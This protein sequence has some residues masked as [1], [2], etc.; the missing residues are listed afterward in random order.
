M[1]EK[2]S[3]FFGSF[4]PGT[5]RRLSI[6]EFRNLQRQARQL[7]TDNE[8]LRAQLEVREKPIYGPHSTHSWFADLVRAQH[9]GHG[10][11]GDGGSGAAAER[12]S[13]HNR[14]Q[15]AEDGRRL[16]LLRAEAEYAAER[17]LSRSP[18]E[19]ALLRRWQDRGGELFEMHQDLRDLERRALNRTD[20]T[21]GYFAPP[22]WLV[23]R[24]VHAPRAGA[25]FAALWQRLPMPPGISSINL[26]RF[27]AGEE[28]GAMTDGASVPSGGGTDSALTAD[29]ITIAAQTDISLQWLDQTPAPVD[30]TLG[31]DMAEDFQIQLD[32]Q[33]L[34]GSGS[35]GQAQGVISGGA[36]AAANLIWLSN[37][38]N[39]ASQ[40]W[41]NGG[42]GHAS[43][44]VHQFASE[45]MSKIGTYR[46]LP[47]THYVMN[48]QAWAI[49]SAAVDGQ[50]RPLNAGTGERQLHNLPVVIDQNLPNTFGG[51]SA[52]T[53]GV[54]N[55]V[56]SPTD[57]NGTWTP[58]LCGRWED[59]I[60]W[61]SEPEVRVMLEV[62]SGTLQARFQVYCYVAAA[63]NRVVWGGSNQSFSGTDQSG[64][65]NAGAAVAYGG[66]SQYTTNGVLQATSLGF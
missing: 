18:Q 13:R 1:S 33:L 50:N 46:G 54:S 5:N 62:L 20:G 35:S 66:M 59:C 16:A 3:E 36:L 22:G 12:L 10:L 9:P 31:A 11:D 64:G 14:Y 15:H 25:P 58:I 34:L 29:L 40:S 52:P 44:G 61:Q 55:G 63:P 6:P 19:A 38:N 28:S 37:T 51:A 56:T 8:N 41:A 48:L 23:D 26:P 32:G 30:E 21:G 57:G 43:S 4:G 65:V 60:F 7:E 49:Y 47:P 39:T 17:A 42:S 2:I 24:F 45:L 27:K 53:I